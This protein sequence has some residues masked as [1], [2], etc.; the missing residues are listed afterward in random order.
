MNTPETILQELLEG[1]ARFI[2]GKSIHTNDSSLLKLKDLATTGQFPKAVVLC[3]SD[4]RAPVEIIFDQDIGDLFVIRVAG[5]IIAPSLIGSIEFAISTFGT[6]LVLVMG[7]TQCGAIKATLDHINHTEV[8]ATENIHDIV[9]RIKP[10]IYLLTQNKEIK[11]CD[12]M[13]MAVEMNVK[14]SVHQLKF[15]SRLIETQMI[16]KKLEIHGA[17]LDLKSGKVNLIKNLF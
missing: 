9:S 14:A 6:N 16:A 10:H 12:H 3:C 7:H 13:D 15:S 5:N 17:V 1:N 11:A 2:D 8:I 4:S